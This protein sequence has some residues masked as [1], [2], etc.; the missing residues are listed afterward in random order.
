MQICL[1]LINDRNDNSYLRSLLRLL[2]C[3]I[4]IVNRKVSYECAYFC[5]RIS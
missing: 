3:G 5:F 4:V 2:F 1:S